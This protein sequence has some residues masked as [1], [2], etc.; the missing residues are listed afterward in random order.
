MVEISGGLDQVLWLANQLPGTCTC[1]L[2]HIFLSAYTLVLTHP[3]AMDLELDGTG[4]GLGTRSKRYAA[5]I[6]NGV[7]SS[8]SA[9]VS[10]CSA[11]IADAAGATL[12]PLTMAW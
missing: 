5:V 7:V 11:P 4:F 6:E 1:I 3:Q 2:Q 12:L 8:N 10:V 9:S